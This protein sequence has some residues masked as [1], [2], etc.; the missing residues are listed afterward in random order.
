MNIVD[1][2]Y[3][4]FSLRMCVL[5]C[6]FSCV[7]LTFAAGWVLVVGFRWGAAALWTL[8]LV[9]LVFP[10]W[11][12]YLS[13]HVWINTQACQKR[14]QI[15]ASWTDKSK[16]NTQTNMLFS[17]DANGGCAR[18]AVRLISTGQQK[19]HT[20]HPKWTNLPWACLF[21]SFLPQ[22]FNSAR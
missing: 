19:T 6:E 5:R 1:W 22:M 11:H 13:A 12:R 15:S 2:L 17:V 14:R 8:G 10:L 18:H 20:Q 9:T 4:L 16:I 21:K 7:W 3:W